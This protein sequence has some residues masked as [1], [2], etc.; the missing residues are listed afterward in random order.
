MSRTSSCATDSGLTRRACLRR[1]SVGALLAMP[2]GVWAQSR[3]PAASVLLLGLFHF[4]NPGLDAVRYTPLDVM[5]PAAQADLEGLADRL[6]GFA[7]TRVLLEYR[8]ASDAVIN[9]RYARY[10]QDRFELPNN[11]IYQL[12]F[13]VARRASL[14]RV[15]GFD[16]DAPGASDALWKALP[17]LPAT[18]ERLMA[19]IQAESQRL[20]QAHRSLS[21]RELVA[22][23]NAPEEDRRNK[24]FYMLLNDAGAADGRF[25]GADAAAHWWHRNLRMYARLQQHAAPGE[26]VLAIAGSGHTAILR[27]LLL[28]DPDRVAEDPRAYL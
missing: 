17:E 20:Q 10:R 23:C 1:I 12:G 5:R 21:L 7:P 13:R 11:E 26:R 4:D 16:L 8:E 19:L 6:A 18:Q 25:L 15:H 3:L 22:L 28:A 27:D 14:A 24:G 9:E 2:P